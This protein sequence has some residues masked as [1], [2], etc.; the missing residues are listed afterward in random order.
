MSH[1]DTTLVFRTEVP[2]AT[3]EELTAH[4]EAGKK[5]LAA[6]VEK[7]TGEVNASAN[8]HAHTLGHKAMTITLLPGRP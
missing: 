5:W 8:E 4:Q 7:M 2:D 3:P 6:M 1:Y